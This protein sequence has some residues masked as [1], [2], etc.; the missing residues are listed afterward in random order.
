MHTTQALYSSRISPVK[1]YREY[2]SNQKFLEIITLEDICS[3]LK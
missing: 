2:S 3:F 1:H